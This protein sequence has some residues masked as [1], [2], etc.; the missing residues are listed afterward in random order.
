V[1]PTFKPKFVLVG[2]KLSS[3]L[4]YQSCQCANTNCNCKAILVNHRP[5]TIISLE[6]QDSKSR[7]EEA[8]IELTEL[9]TTKEEDSDET[10][11]MSPQEKN[12]LEYLYDNPFAED[13]LYRIRNRGEV[14]RRMRYLTGMAAIGGFLFGYDTGKRWKADPTYDIIS[15]I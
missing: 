4:Q 3:L 10:I 6:P 5:A 7:P 15:S 12:K 9:T 11:R 1:L 8:T 13:G 2:G 14:M